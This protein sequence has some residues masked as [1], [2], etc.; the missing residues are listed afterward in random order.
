MARNDDRPDAAI[1]RY[2]AAGMPR[3]EGWLHRFAAELIAAI[4]QIQH[5]GLVRGAVG[6]IGVHHGKLL[7]LLLLTAARDERAFAI[8]V[9]EKQ[10]LNVDGSGRGD[11]ERFLQN[12]RVFSGR[13]QD[14]LIIPKS[15][16]TV[17][18]GEIVEKLGPA[19]LISI[20]GGH[21]A[22]CTVNDLRLAEASLHNRGVV[23]L[24]DYFNASWPDVATGA[25]EYFLDRGSK[26]RPFAIGPNKLFLSDLP[27][28][29]YYR[30]AL[31]T[32][33]R[34]LKRSRM[35]QTE[36]DLYETD[37]PVLTPGELLRLGIKESTLGPYAIAA[38]ALV[39]RLLPSRWRSR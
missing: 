8:D 38:N 28:H 16:L 29:D 33:F 2:I 35:F 4:S 19:R 7:I 20:D 9:F 21:T 13:E 37:L 17:T 10:E 3:I 23:I 14:I 22:E 31:Q 5:E 36:V 6:E 30:T 15:S 32:R 34:P 18:P 24:D 25:A 27:N 12:V 1:A 11:R 26:L 39:K